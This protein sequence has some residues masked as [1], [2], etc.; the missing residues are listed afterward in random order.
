MS[1]ESQEVKKQI[2]DYL[3]SKSAAEHLQNLESQLK[4]YATDVPDMC[5]RE[6]WP[7][8][9][10]YTGHSG[11]RLTKTVILG[12]GIEAYETMI[13]FGKC[14]NLLYQYAPYIRPW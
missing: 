9:M 11:K 14:T 12:G 3:S 4:N 1:G 7:M 8:F 5:K 6:I 2:T 13:V 10:F